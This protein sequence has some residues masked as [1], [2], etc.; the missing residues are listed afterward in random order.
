MSSARTACPRALPWR[1]LDLGVLPA[2]RTQSIYHALAAMVARTGQP[3]IAFAQP[4]GPLVCLGCHSGYLD[5]VDHAYCAAAGIPVLRRMIGGGTVL[6]DRPQLF[7][8]Y[9]LPARFLPGRVDAVYRELI[10]V[11][12]DAL[13]R[14]G[15]PAS[16][17]QP[18][19]IWVGKRK[20]GGSGSGLVD[21]ALVLTGNFLLD[22]DFHMLTRA[23]AYSDET[24]RRRAR[25]LVRRGMTTLREA[26]G[27]APPV[28]TLRDHF[29]AALRSRFACELSHDRPSDGEWARA[30]EY[31]RRLRDPEW[32]RYVEQRYPGVRL[33]KIRAGLYLASLPLEGAPDGCGTPG[34]WTLVIEDGICTDVAWSPAED[35]VDL[36]TRLAVRELLVGR[37]LAPGCSD[38]RRSLG[39]FVPAAACGA[40]DRALARL[41]AE[42]TAAAEEFVG[43]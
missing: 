4:D 5:E 23:L 1:V 41:P 35:W 13:G 26:C 25:T 8:Q 43:V 20:V 31:D 40:L 39:D 11:A 38:V 33:L 2:V 19:D 22:F 37:R 6:L 24:F 32:L 17:G 12:V 15:L 9:V 36:D 18:G 21:E 14:L 7:F 28:A 29:L 3:T 10:G 16:L 27:I 30:A 34:R 42:A